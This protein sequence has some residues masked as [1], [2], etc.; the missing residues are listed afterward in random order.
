MLKEG[1]N[2]II[3]ILS[4]IV[5]VL[6]GI[7]LI[8]PKEIPLKLIESSPS[9]NQENIEINSTLK[10]TFNLAINSGELTILTNPNFE[11]SSINYNEN[12]VEVK[13]VNPLEY[14]I[15]YSIEI[16]SNKYKDFY[17]VIKFKTE[18]KEVPP[19]T[20]EQQK[21]F[22]KQLEEETY[23]KY[24][25]FDYLP[26]KTDNY[27]IDYYSSDPLILGVFLKTDAPEIRKEVLDWIRSKEEK[28]GTHQVKW[29]LKPELFGL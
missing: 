15:E 11:Y 7:K 20:Q 16:K 14:E 1:R 2:K 22:Y 8:L 18:K 17:E 12:I 27:M 13:P 29:I 28:P 21:E 10:F 6:L 26:H 19:Y 9:S 5:G 23:K 4:I 3:I 24:P 25:L